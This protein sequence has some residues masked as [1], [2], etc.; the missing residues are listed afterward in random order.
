[1]MGSERR[2]YTH[3]DAPGQTFLGFALLLHGLPFL[4]VGI[5][6]IYNPQPF[7]FI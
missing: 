6:R 5:E 4:D 7:H 2:L 1:M 3:R